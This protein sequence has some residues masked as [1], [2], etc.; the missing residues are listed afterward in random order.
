MATFRAASAPAASE[1]PVS[2][3]EL[4]ESESLSEAAALDAEDEDEE[5]EEGALDVEELEES[6]ELRRPEVAPLTGGPAPVDRERFEPEPGLDGVD[7]ERVHDTH[8]RLL[9]DNVYGTIDEDVWR[10][11]FTANALYYNIADFSVVGLRRRCRGCCRATLAPDRRCRDALSRG[12]G[13][14]AARGPFRGQARLRARAGQCRADRAAEALLAGVPPARLFDETQKLF[15]T[16]HGERSFEVLRQH[17]LLEELFP[18][19]EQYL[20]AHP[21]SAV[22]R[23]LRLGLRNTDARVAADKPVT[24]DVPVCTAALWSDRGIDRSRCRRSAGTRSARS[25]APVSARCARP[26]H[27]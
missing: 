15:L 18:T 24:A 13:A 23:L 10:R 16:G 26:R 11:D 3:V 12:S 17:A 9:R 2:E 4:E 14:H 22:E 25:A 27:A 8:G 1:E 20:R 6:A 19:V 21:T 5:E 7:H